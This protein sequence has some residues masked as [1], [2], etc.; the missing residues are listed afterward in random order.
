MWQV[1]ASAV[2]AA[3]SILVEII[4]PAD[5]GVILADT[6]VVHDY[7]THAPFGRVEGVVPAA[8]GPGDDDVRPMLVANKRAAGDRQ[9]LYTLAGNAHRRVLH[10]GYPLTAEPQSLAPR[11]F[12]PCSASATRG[13]KTLALTGA[14]LLCPLRIYH[15][16]LFEG[17][18]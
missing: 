5:A 9:D 4:E 11:A 17:S 1:C 3:R 10:V 13:L 18:A 6:G 7:P 2:A 8:I 12:G 14:V 15:L 16:S